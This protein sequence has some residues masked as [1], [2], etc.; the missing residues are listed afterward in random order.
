MPRCIFFT[1]KYFPQLD[2]AVSAD[3]EGMLEFW[4]PST[5]HNY[6]HPP[7]LRWDSKMDTDLYRLLGD[8]TYAV[9]LTFSPDG[10]LLATLGADR[11]VGFCF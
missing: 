1:F 4:S 9:N 5:K 8:K 6:G 3:T 11:K 2:A 10:S 7:S